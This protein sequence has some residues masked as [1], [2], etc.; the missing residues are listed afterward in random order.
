MK[1]MNFADYLV[2]HQREDG[3][4]VRTIKFAARGSCGFAPEAQLPTSMPSA[5]A[6][7][8]APMVAT[9]GTGRDGMF[10]WEPDTADEGTCNPNSEDC[11][12]WLLDEGSL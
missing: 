11:G 4:K 2:L 1:M 3:A 8:H 6:M 12:Y 5:F 9:K 10:V 7:V